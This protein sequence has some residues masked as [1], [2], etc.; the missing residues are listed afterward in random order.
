MS[1]DSQFAFQQFIIEQNKSVFKVGTDG[2]LL[3]AWCNPQGCKTALDIGT[4]TGL[5]TLM[6]AQQEVSLHI[7]A[8]DNME[9][10]VE[11]ARKNIY[12]SPFKNIIEVVQTSFQD[13]QQT[14]D[15]FD[16]IISN[17]PFYRSGLLSKNAVLRQAKHTHALSFE[18]LFGGVQKLLSE[19]GLFYVI[20][21]FQYLEIIEILCKTL[22]LF[23][24]KQQA[25]TS[26]TDSNPHR[27]LLS[28]GKEKQ[29]T[30]HLPILA[31]RTDQ[32]TYSEDYKVLTN[33][34]YQQRA[35]L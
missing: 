2:V 22:G 8:I 27:I 26:F 13:F 30:L 24:V 14:H 16:I 3:G 25:V 19:Q 33:Q 29:T 31:I 15:R 28:V 35:Y 21:P 4:G 12:S 32:F 11:I 7:T 34:F 1:F 20:L 10:A 23:I 17:P 18:E 6:M 5:L 9:A